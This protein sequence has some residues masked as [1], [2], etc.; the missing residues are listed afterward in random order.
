MASEAERTSVRRLAR[1][2]LARV[3]GAAGRVVA[4]RGRDRWSVSDCREAVVLRSGESIELDFELERAPGPGLAEVVLTACLEIHDSH[5][6]VHRHL[7]S[8]IRI[9]VNGVAVFDG[10]HHWRSHEET[11]AF[12]NPFDFACDAALLRAGRNTV[13]IEN[14]TT[15]EA[16]GEFLDATVFEA[17]G[18]E[19]GWVKL[20][21]VVVDAVAVD[22]VEPPP[23]WPRVSGVPRTAV[24]GQP[25]VVE[26]ALPEGDGRDVAARGVCNA[27]VTA[28]GAEVEFGA[29]RHL[30][31]VVPERAGC[32][33][34]VEWAA[35]DERG[36][37]E[38]ETVYAA[39]GES[40]LIIGPGAESTYW[41]SLLR[42]A[43]DFYEL[44]TGTCLRISIDDYLAD[45]HHVPTPEWL[46]LIRYLARRRRHYALQRLRVPPYSRIA[47]GDL[48][49]LAGVGGAELFAGVSIPEPVL[50]L[51]RREAAGDLKEALDGYLAFFAER[52]R[53]LRLPGHKLVT[54]DSGGALCGHYYR[55]GLDVH[56]AEIGPACNCFEE[57]CCRGAAGAFG[58]PWG[59]AVAMHWYCGQ[60]GHYA[61]DVARVRYAR[62]VMLSSYLA[63]ARHIV[64]EGGVFDNLPVYNYILSEESWRDFGRRYHDE[65]LPAVRREFARTLDFHRAQQL[66]APRVR[67][68]VL[69]GTNDLFSGTFSAAC[70]PQGDMGLARGWTLLKVFLPHVS[71]G[72]WGI[73]H[74][75][76]QRRWYSWT[77]H[78]QV[79]VVPAEAGSEALDGYGLL[80]L[81][82]WNTMT[83]ELHGK[84]CAYVEGGGT[85]FAA[86]PHFT[87][88]T[89]QK[90]EWT[91]WNGGDLTRLCG[92]RVKGLGGRIERVRF[93]TDLFESRLPREF[94]LADR[95]PLFVSDFDEK[96]P[97]FSLDVTCFG[98]AIDVE[99]A[100]VL[101]VSQRGEPVVLRRRLGR[102]WVY[103]LNTHHSLGRG[104]MLDLAEGLLGAL[105]Q[106]QDAPL[107]M[108]DPTERVA[109]FEYPDRGFTRYFLLN[110]DWA[111]EGAVSRVSVCLGGRDLD[112]DVPSGVPVQVASDGV[113]HVVLADPRVQVAGWRRTG[114]RWEVRIAGGGAESIAVYAPEGAEVELASGAIE[115]E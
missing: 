66:P 20:S 25:F 27:S 21:T 83:D 68:G 101:A 89:A 71:W 15:R 18:A 52:M 30:F 63:G 23:R 24:A 86:L 98:C 17:L 109:W 106:A 75:R 55:L 88:D 31:E 4:F 111:G 7:N 37:V 73:D 49:M 38:V 19:A 69:R 58:K 29:C 26:L 5:A 79:D 53:E 13:R 46:P 72:R 97:V 87:S 105:V 48:A 45:L 100:E 59:V 51:H 56:V 10:I 115:R 60:G 94:V 9:E 67:F 44:G 65:P 95:D 80:A 33:C 1:V 43:R 6:Y 108:T 82:S 22:F 107:R 2:A 42:A 78:G 91:C 93:S 54:F 57:T 50:H 62:L 34:A 84:L 8:V 90:M 16:L 41:R 99:G 40:D 102:G 85:L 12:W 61:Y 28:L 76:P 47:H 77:P 114:K 92:V 32:P 113:C 35:G 64:W 39:R 74:G 3:P 112:V 70:S 11:V 36:R 14:R 110:T 104:R 103:L 96:Y 81:V